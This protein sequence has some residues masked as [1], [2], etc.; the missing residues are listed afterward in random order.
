MSVTIINLQQ[1]MAT[2]CICGTVDFSRWGV[3]ISSETALIISNE[4]TEDWSGA[5]AC[6]ECWK[7][8]ETGEFVGTYPKY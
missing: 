6:E 3:P 1:P 5:P 7:K 2:C 4:S 8:H